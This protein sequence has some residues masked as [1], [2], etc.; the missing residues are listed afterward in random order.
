M[1][2]ALASLLGKTVERGASDLHLGIGEPPVFRRDGELER[3]GAPL[4]REQVEA[5][6]LPLLGERR[7]AALE[8]AGSVDL[9]LEHDGA[10]FR[11]NVFRQRGQLAV[12]IR[13]LEERLR[14]LEE[15]GLPP[16]LERLA[17]FR[18][19]LVLVTGPTGSGKS[20]TLAALLHLIHTRRSCHILTIEDPI[21]YLHRG[22][23]GIV[24]QREVHTDVPSFAAAVR[25]ALREDPN[26]ILIGEMRDLETMR[27][28]ITAA[29][30]GHLVFST[31]HT[32]DATGALD[33]LVGAFPSE[34]QG[35]VKTQLSM[36]LRAVV[37]QRLVR[38]VRA[39]GRVPAVEVL[40]I[41][42]AV[43]NLIRTY[44][45]QAIVSAIEA[46]TAQG[47]QTLEQSLAALVARGVVRI[48]D[49]RLLARDERALEER[50][51]L[52]RAGVL[53]QEV[54]ASARIGGPPVS[55]SRADGT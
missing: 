3:E 22:G 17:G 30:T 37:A 6:V 16:T 5:I 54:P 36:V 39:S 28:A 44:K 4:T 19:G 32:G 53:P 10:R 27:A 25:S 40:M 48:E 1:S 7:Q 14:S 38:R 33:R 31:L 13:R 41:T 24:R 50:I 2:P 18:D 12:A 42:T 23:P 55:R 29:E 43:A 34:E 52:A 45:P 20:T 11:V 8:Q 9:A 35:A 46:G 21:E 51:R 47:M 26:V 49:A 15:L